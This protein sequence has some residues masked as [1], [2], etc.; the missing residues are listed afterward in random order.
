MSRELADLRILA[1]GIEE[2]HVVDH[3]RALSDEVVHAGDETGF[4]SD[5]GDGLDVPGRFQHQAPVA[6][7]YPVGQALVRIAQFR[8]LG[9][10]FGTGLENLDGSIPAKSRMTTLAQRPNKR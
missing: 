4:G 9:C 7:A 1:P 8:A 3:R 10:A 6:V 2:Q 5:R